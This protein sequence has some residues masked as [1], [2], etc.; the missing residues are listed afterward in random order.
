MHINIQN[1]NKTVSNNNEGQI[2]RQNEI[3]AKDN[4]S[5]QQVIVTLTTNLE[6]VVEGTTLN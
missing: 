1:Q 4:N 5:H 2:T 6:E 3:D